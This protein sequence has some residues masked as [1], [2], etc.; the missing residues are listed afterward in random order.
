[1]RLTINKAV[2]IMSLI[3]LAVLP[4][5]NLD[6][7][8]FF[9]YLLFVNLILSYAWNLCGGYAGLILL[10]QS[11]FVGVGAYI[12]SLLYLSGVNIYLS[13]IVGGFTAACLAVVLAFPLLKLRGLY[14]ALGTLLLNFIFQESFA[15]WT[16]VG[17]ATGFS[18]PRPP[19]FSLSAIYYLALVFAVIEIVV[20]AVIVNSKIGLALTSIGDDADA[21]ESYGVPVFRLKVLSLVV[22]SFFSGITG[23]IIAIKNS[24]IEPYSIFAMSRSIWSMNTVL[25]GGTGTL[26][27]PAV[28][29]IIITV[30]QELLAG[31]AELHLVILGLILLVIIKIA[32][33]GVL[34]IISGFKQRLI[35]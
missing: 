20:I 29:S 7:A 27:G 15:N 1:M 10:G 21:A 34:G 23:S 35:R 11:L 2:G 30:V 14:F 5:F 8:L 31:Y 24:W 6:Y 17:G 19:N 33:N 28:G 9:G 32:P 26:L 16:A 3:V 18:L 4:I 13:M 12:F 25:I 22:A